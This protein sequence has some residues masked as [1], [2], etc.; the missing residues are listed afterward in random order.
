MSSFEAVRISFL[1]QFLKTP[2][3]VMSHI[4]NV[5]LS[6]LALV[7]SS[8][9][10]AGN[11]SGNFDLTYLGPSNST[12]ANGAALTCAAATNCSF[13]RAPSVPDGE[14]RVAIIL[15]TNV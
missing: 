8:A 6:L 13:T 1:Q 9:S 3:G 2:R 10:W 7:V 5:V 12:I 14:S 15:S 4:R 11:L